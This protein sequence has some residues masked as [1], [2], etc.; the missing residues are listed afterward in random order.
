MTACPSEDE[1]V[2]L[3]EGAL[4][5]ASLAAIEAHVDGCEHCGS[6]IASLGALGKAEA[7]R[8]IGRY[9]LDRR[10]AAGG[11]GEVWAAW[12]P[13]L[14]REI[15]VKL[16]RPDRADDTKERER[17]LREARAL[18]RLTHPNVLA[19]HDVGEAD[20]E[21]FLATELVAG[22]TLAT[23]GGAS[24]DWRML[25][26][27]Y[28]QAA[29]GL[30]A[31]HAAGLVHRDV[32][33]AN[34]LLGADGRV[35]V[36]DFGLAVRSHTPSPNAPTE[37][38]SVDGH[39][40]ITASGLVAGTPAYMAPEQRAGRPADAPADQF[41]L[42]V[43]LGEAIAGR[44]PPT[45]LDRA[46]LFAFVLERRSR[47]G[48]LDELCNAIARG[49]S[50]EPAARFPDM[51]ALADALDAILARH[52]GADAIGTAAPVAS[53]APAERTELARNVTRTRRGRAAMA[54]AIAAVAVV[55]GST[56]TWLAIRG[57]APE[58]PAA[59]APSAGGDLVEGAAS[60]SAENGRAAL[61][62]NGSSTA[63]PSGGSNA[64]PSGGGSDAMPS[65]GGSD[66]GN[67]GPNAAPLR[68]TYRTTTPGSGSGSAS[69]TPPA[70]ATTFDDVD[71]AIKRHDGPACRAA[72]RA[73]VAPP[74]DIRVPYAHA[75][76]AMVAGD[77]AGGI[78]EVKAVLAREGTPE[79]AADVIADEY[80]PPGNDP[81]TRLRRLVKQT[82]H[83]KYEC[84]MYVAPAR[85]ASAAAQTDNDR[86]AAGSVLDQIAKCFSFR[87][88]CDE[89]R[90]L[91][92]EAQVMIPGL[93]L[94]E[95]AAACR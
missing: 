95:L 48:G 12:D 64:M 23:R 72:L 26:R 43:A 20:G 40:S 50:R 83:F 18:A 81:D 62:S 70:S 9:Q 58:S 73:L 91:L 33:P 27:L 79:A 24:A 22:D 19:V 28:V 16:V 54:I 63:M 94:N 30:A 71:A 45:D 5:D 10:I 89:A 36:A 2:R 59:I 6:V 52:P 65:G 25:A 60:G 66:A 41:A 46:G 86:R 69:A 57:R 80:C 85:A 35:R 67:G 7:P 47:D 14:R 61:P 34:L 11:M 31:A 29:R 77:C 75:L 49:L 4:A 84:A 8:R 90:A 15:A 87:G 32:K 74:N 78:R 93:A 82:Q 68:P 13:E 55:A 42:C 56:A 39:P 37:T 1:L 88:Q 76:C 21:V 53:P 17:L 3:V 92:G 51:A 38:P 44:R